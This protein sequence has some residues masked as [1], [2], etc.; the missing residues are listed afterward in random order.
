MNEGLLSSGPAPLAQTLVQRS[1]FSHPT[2]MVNN[3]VV[4]T[5]EWLIIHYWKAG[6]C[7]QNKNR[8]GMG[9]CSGGAPN[10]LGVREAP[11]ENSSK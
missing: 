10:R 4:T 6:N 11:F 8:Q 7:G 1:L 5:I 2:F 3:N 9:G